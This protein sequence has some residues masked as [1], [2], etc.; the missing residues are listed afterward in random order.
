MPH[1]LLNVLQLL[2]TFFC[3]GYVILDVAIYGDNFRTA[4]KASSSLFHRR[5][6][7]NIVADTLCATAL[8]CASIAIATLIG[9]WA[10]LLSFVFPTGVM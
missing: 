9:I 7:D 2:L 3:F 10:Y 1:H 8:T 5:G 6:W 4:G